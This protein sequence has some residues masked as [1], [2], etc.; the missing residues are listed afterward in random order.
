VV[1]QLEGAEPQRHA[2]GLVE[3]LQGAVAVRGQRPVEPQLPAQGPIGELGRQRRLARLQD[4]RLAEGGIEGK[5][6]ESASL[7]D[8][9]QHLGR[10]APRGCRHA[11]ASIMCLQPAGM[12]RSLPAHEDP[13]PEP[14]LE[15]LLPR[16]SSFPVIC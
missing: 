4:A 1:E 12:R 11:R 13:F 3:I 2:H 9:H 14:A 5:V 6:G 16:L 10:D 8:A 7:R 15:A